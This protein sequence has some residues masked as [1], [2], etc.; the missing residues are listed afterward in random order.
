M[1]D[2]VDLRGLDTTHYR[3]QVGMV[4]Q[5]PYLFHGTLLENIRY[6]R[7][8]A[9]LGQVVE[10]ALAANAHEFILALGQ[11]DKSAELGLY[12][13]KGE[14][15]LECAVRNGLPSVTLKDPRGLERLN[16]SWTTRKK[17]AIFFYDGDGELLDVFGGE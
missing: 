13:S 16:L 8:D 10:A 17:P 9:D 7:P 12:N 3:R 11:F 6:G 15:R 1:I 4:L 14:R 5:E 2:G